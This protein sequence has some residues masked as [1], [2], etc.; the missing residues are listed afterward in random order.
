ME[1]YPFVQCM[2]VQDKTLTRLLHMQLIQGLFRVKDWRILK[3]IPMDV[4]PGILLPHQLIDPLQ[5][6]LPELPVEPLH[7]CTI[8]ILM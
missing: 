5:K 1:L 6:E 2:T 7:H 3:I 8:D 4:D